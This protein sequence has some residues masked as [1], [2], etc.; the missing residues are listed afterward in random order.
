MKLRIVVLLLAITYLSSCQKDSL[1][2]YAT[3]SLNSQNPAVVAGTTTQGTSKPNTN[4]YI[5]IQLAA[6]SVNTDATMIVFKPNAKT[7]Y[8]NTED[9]I[10]FQ[11]LGAVSLASLSSDN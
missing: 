11:G 6:D 1:A 7:T 9:A 2:P 3:Q 8:V 10:Y 4:E 5:D